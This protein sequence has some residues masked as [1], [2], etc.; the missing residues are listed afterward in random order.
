MPGDPPLPAHHEAQMMPGAEVA[1]PVEPAV[2][3]GIQKR[4]D[5]RPG[6]RPGRRIKLQFA[7]PFDPHGSTHSQCDTPPVS[8]TLRCCARPP[9]SSNSSAPVPVMNACAPSAQISS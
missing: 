9:S 8:P 3:T 1:P 6:C 2:E 5:L 4:A 7:N